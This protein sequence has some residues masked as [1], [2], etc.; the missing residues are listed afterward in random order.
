MAVREHRFLKKELHIFKN[1]FIR[2][3]TFR[4]WTVKWDSHSPSHFGRSLFSD[5]NR[6]GIRRRK[7]SHGSERGKVDRC[8]QVE[9]SSS[10]PS[11]SL[12]AFLLYNNIDWWWCNT[13]IMWSCLPP[14][15]RPPPLFFNSLFITAIVLQT[16]F[17]FRPLRERTRMCHAHKNGRGEGKVNDGNNSLCVKRGVRWGWTRWISQADPTFCLASMDLAMWARPGRR[18]GNA[19][20][21]SLMMTSS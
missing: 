6:T 2:L 8:A 1:I 4:I 5:T 20:V 18:L 3:V 12:M 10:L 17:S 7:A 15:Y 16:I 21:I 9:S 19:T 11:I 13:L 14:P